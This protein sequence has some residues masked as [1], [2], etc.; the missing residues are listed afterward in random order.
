MS[1]MIYL[2]ESANIIKLVRGDTYSTSLRIESDTSEDG[3]YRLS[4]DDA[5][6]FG[7]MY[8]HQK[9]EDAIIRKKFMKADQGSDGNVLI[10]LD[11]ADTLDL[12]PGVYYYAVKLRQNSQVS[13]IINKAKLVLLD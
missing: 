10:Q 9:F 8:P 11:P 5:L 2:G 13:T 1:N 3:L 6:Y 12:D 4:A 7:V